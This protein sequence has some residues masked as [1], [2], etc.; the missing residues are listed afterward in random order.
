MDGIRLSSKTSKRRKRVIRRWRLDRFGDEVKLSY[1][2][3][4]MLK[5]MSSRRILANIKIER[6]MKQQELVNDV[7]MEWE[8]VVN[9]VAK[10]ELGEKIIVCVVEQLGGGM[11]RSKI[12]LT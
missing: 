11:S 9:K 8:S 3:A 10:C 5:C 6:G 2:N 1:Q 12:K 7:V 4:L